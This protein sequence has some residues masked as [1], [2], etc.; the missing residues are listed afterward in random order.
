[1][2]QAARRVQA[3]ESQR[4]EDSQRQPAR[5]HEVLTCGQAL[6]VADILAEIEALAEVIDYGL[7]VANDAP[8][9]DRGNDSTV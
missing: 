8:A 4:E 9:A 3:L 1:M 6:E 2:R 5:V 7:S